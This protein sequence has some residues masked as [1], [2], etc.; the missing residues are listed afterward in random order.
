MTKEEKQAIAS[1]KKLLGEARNQLKTLP[2]KSSVRKTVDAV[3]KDVIQNL[4]AAG[5][6]G[7]L[8]PC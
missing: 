3:L 8:P 5:P 6:G 1:V 4:K 7:V 2:A